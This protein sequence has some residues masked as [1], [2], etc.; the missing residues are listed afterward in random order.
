MR[1]RWRRWRPW[2]K[3]AQPHLRWTFCY[4]RRRHMP[5]YSRQMRLG[6]C[7]TAPCGC[8]HPLAPLT[9]PSSP[10]HAPSAPPAR[11]VRPAWYATPAPLWLLMRGH[12]N[13]C[14]CTSAYGHFMFIH[15]VHVCPCLWGVLCARQKQRT[16]LRRRVE[17]TTAYRERERERERERPVC[18][19]E[20]LAAVTYLGADRP[21]IGT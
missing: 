15:S 13:A 21:C 11:P 12:F 6:V 9:R 19:G 20:M 5:A 14:N 3:G 1:R 7:S 16:L 4:K 18:L 2:S 17:T 8:L 10:S